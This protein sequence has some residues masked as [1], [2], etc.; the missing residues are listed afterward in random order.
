MKHSYPFWC[1]AAAVLLFGP[2]GLRML[3]WQRSQP[4]AV[5]GD[6]ARAGE[7][8]FKHE[9]QVNDPLCPSGDGLGPVFNAKSCVACHN[10][11]G[12]GGAG[13]VDH[14]VTTYLVL[15]IDGRPLRQG[16]VHAFAT[17]PT[18]Q[19]NLSHVDSTL[20]PISRPK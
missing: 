19:E 11:G 3:F 2:V 6:Q 4:L 17:A 12:A 16:V 13:G 8:L 14:N 15:N 20:L 10:Q 1:A 5:D 18:H 9:W 7:V